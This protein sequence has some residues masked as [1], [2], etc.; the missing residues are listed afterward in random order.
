[1][2]AETKPASVTDREIATTRLLNAPRSLVWK[3]WTD[4]ERIKQWWGPIGFTTTT[5]VFEFRPGGQW[6]FTMHGPDG[7]D[8]RN[9]VTYTTIDE[10]ERIEYDH[11]PSPIFHATVTF[12]EE[13]TDKTKLSMQMLFLTQE[14]RDRTIEKYG[15]I[16]GLNQTLG[17]L[18]ECLAKTKI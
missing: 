17:R 11:G 18:E 2:S 8:Y 14:E 12:D 3:V 6:L 9:D 4:P 1:M 10:P 13:G 15:A 7:T 16:E 5:K